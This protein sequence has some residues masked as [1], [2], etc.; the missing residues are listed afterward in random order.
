MNLRSYG[1][2]HGPIAL[3]WKSTPPDPTWSKV[4][5]HQL[6]LHF[7]SVR[8]NKS[9]FFKSGTERGFGKLLMQSKQ[10]RRWRKYIWTWRITVLQTCYDVA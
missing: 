2:Q 8:T 6:T 5:N 3:R 1:G 4:W 10:L 7:W 9:Y